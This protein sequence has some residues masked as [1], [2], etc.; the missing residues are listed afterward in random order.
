MK[1]RTLLSFEMYTN[2]NIDNMFIFGI[3]EVFIF[4]LCN[5]NPI[6]TQGLYRKL[7]IVKLP[8][9]AQPEIFW[10]VATT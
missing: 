4:L 10:R 7:Y 8:Y 5:S 9:K 3:A 2:D 1:C 6:F